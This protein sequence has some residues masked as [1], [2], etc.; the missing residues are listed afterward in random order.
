MGLQEVLLKAEKYPLSYFKGDGEGSS[1]NLVYMEVVSC[2]ASSI[3]S[4]NEPNATVT[5][6]DER[7]AFFY[8]EYFRAIYGRNPSDIEIKDHLT[9]RNNY[10]TVYIRY[11][12]HDNWEEIVRQRHTDLV[13][14]P[15]A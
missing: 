13:S 1:C 6:L 9:F 11:L 12:L 7:K 15:D 8:V 14:L 10:I 4:Y 5:I 2:H 3:Q